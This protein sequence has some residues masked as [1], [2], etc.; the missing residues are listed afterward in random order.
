MA[1]AIMTATTSTPITVQNTSGEP[2]EPSVVIGSSAL[3][4]ASTTA[5]NPTPDWR[6]LPRRAG[7]T[8]AMQPTRRD[9]ADQAQRGEG[10]VV[11]LEPG[12][13]RRSMLSAAGFGVHDAISMG[14]GSL[15]LVPA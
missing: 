11:R 13:R 1:E 12:R 7:Q 8:P 3:V 10:H 15:R 6:S 4:I 9:G 5:S 14:L 2:E